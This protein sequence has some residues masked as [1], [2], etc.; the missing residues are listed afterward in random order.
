MP[1][2]ADLYNF[3]SGPK[4]SDCVEFLSL[5]HPEA[6]II[7]VEESYARSLT[8]AESEGSST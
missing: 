8:P 2:S 3:D 1:A 5:F 6:I 4:T 7:P